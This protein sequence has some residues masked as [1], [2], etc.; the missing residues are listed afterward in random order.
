MID[1]RINENKQTSRREKGK[2]NMKIV[3]QE[4]NEMIIELENGVRIEIDRSMVNII[5]KS[6]KSEVS[7]TGTFID[8]EGN[9]GSVHIH[10]N[11][12][13]LSKKKVNRSDSAGD[14]SLTK[15]FPKGEKTWNSICNIYTEK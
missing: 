5:G 8:Y 15:I 2:Q 14:Y 1:G 7:Q 12:K 10:S 6:H 4:N 3:K 11:L 13:E 9:I